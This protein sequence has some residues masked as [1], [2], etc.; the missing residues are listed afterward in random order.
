MYH[1]RCIRTI[2]GL[3]RDI[4]WTDSSEELASVTICLVHSIISVKTLFFIEGYI[5]E[6][7][8]LLQNPTDEMIW[9]FLFVNLSI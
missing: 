2:F 6:I 7:N 8:R 5:V 4:P 3:I 9:R 1:T